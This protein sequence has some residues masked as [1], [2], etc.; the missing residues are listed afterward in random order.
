LYNV[1]FEEG[2]VFN[3]NSYVK[4]NPSFPYLIGDCSINFK[5]NLLGDKL[6][7]T[8]ISKGYKNYYDDEGYTFDF[9]CEE[10][11]F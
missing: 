2:A 7:G 9:K 3:N 1:W 11:D 6:K 5:A 4:Y 10:F 8:L